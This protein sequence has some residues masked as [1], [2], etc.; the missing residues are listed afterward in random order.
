MVK[1]NDVAIYLID[2]HPS[3]Q[4]VTGGGDRF[5]IAMERAQAKV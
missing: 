2:S 3:M 5:L 1:V 4:Q